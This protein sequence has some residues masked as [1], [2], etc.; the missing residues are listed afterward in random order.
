MN[1]KTNQAL[2]H[3]YSRIEAG[4]AYPD[5]FQATVAKLGLNSANARRLTF[6]FEAH[7]T[8]LNNRRKELASDPCH[9]RAN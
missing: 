1:T 7:E 3:L 6:A 4:M 8:M 2:A 9:P 5:A